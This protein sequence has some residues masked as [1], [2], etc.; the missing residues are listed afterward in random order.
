MIRRSRAS[1]LLAS[2]GALAVI[3]AAGL[4][5]S[6]D[7]GRTPISP[8][9]ATELAQRAIV[10]VGQPEG[11]PRAFRLSSESVN[12]PSPDEFQIS[13]ADGRFGLE[14]HR[15]AGGPVAS[16]FNLTFQGLVEW[17]DTNEDGR[18][19][20]GSI[21]RMV[22]LGSVGFGA[23]PISHTAWT[24]PKGGEV[25]SFLIASNYGPQI[26]LNLTI[27]ERFLPLES[28][29]TLTPMEAKLTIEIRHT[30]VHSDAKLGLLLSLETKGR[31][32]LEDRSW[33]DEN[34]FSDDDHAVNV[35][36]GDDLAPS[37]AFFAWSN[38]AFVNGED[39][40]VTLTGPEMNTSLSN[41]YDVYL[42][43]AGDEGPGMIDIVHDPVI[44]V[45]SAAYESLRNVPPSPTNLQPDYLLYFVSA[46]AVAALVLATVVL[47][48][49]RRRV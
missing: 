45:V 7:S 14:Y 2:A 20:D 35:T 42:A 12:A 34:H 4:S 28:D 17:H 16:S 43:Y 10:W 32:R 33:D 15:V 48:N 11:S 29:L 21:L 13:Y 9:G 41:G 46:A 47:A 23:A 40:D 44:G 39:R 38:H 37:N 31:I 26:A 24:G 49:R 5:S 8:A 1:L 25:H 30:F 18:I 19:D 27:S 6:A 36:E 3:L 22:P